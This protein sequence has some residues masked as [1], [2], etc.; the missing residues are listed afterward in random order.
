MTSPRELWSLVRLMYDVYRLP[1]AAS[2]TLEQRVISAWEP[3][4]DADGRLTCPMEMRL[5]H[6]RT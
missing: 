6:L 4:V 1:P 5:I 3:L 2:T